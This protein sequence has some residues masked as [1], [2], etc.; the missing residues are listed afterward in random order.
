MAFIM[1]AGGVALNGVVA[2]LNC[3]QHYKGD[4]HAVLVGGRSYLSLWYGTP[5][6][7][8]LFS[9]CDRVHIAHHGHGAELEL[10]MHKAHVTFQN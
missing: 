6:S 7:L 1:L 10:T 2:P 5:E 4:P 3:L 9:S 8:V